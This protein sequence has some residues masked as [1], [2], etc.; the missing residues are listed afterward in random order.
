M[1]EETTISFEQLVQQLRANKFNVIL[2]RKKWRD[3]NYFLLTGNSLVGQIDLY[4]YNAIYVDH[5]ELYDKPR[6]CPIF[7]PIPTTQQQ[8]DFLIS[9]LQWLMTEEGYSASDK[10]ETEK[11]VDSYE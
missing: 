4:Y 11:W 8:V 6:K 10:Y 3:Y 9:K 5:K 7:L 1:I 2:P